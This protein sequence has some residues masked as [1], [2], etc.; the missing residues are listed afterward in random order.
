[1]FDDV[2]AHHS[3]F[4]LQ[5]V[6]LLLANTKHCIQLHLLPIA[7]VLNATMA[8]IVSM[9]T[10]DWNNISWGM[11]QFPSSGSGHSLKKLNDQWSLLGAPPAPPCF[12]FHVILL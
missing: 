2:A 1:M 4:H 11:G 7:S 8:M 9:D 10:N 3:L 6:N 5:C 12:V